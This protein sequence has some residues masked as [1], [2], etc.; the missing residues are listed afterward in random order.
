M[1]NCFV[2]CVIL[3]CGCACREYIGLV[4]M[5]AIEE[6]SRDFVPGKTFNFGKPTCTMD[7]E[8]LLASQ[9]SSAENT[10]VIHSK[11]VF[12]SAEVPTSSLPTLV[13]L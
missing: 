6:E 13:E 8:Q 1:S 2:C 5:D 12:S 7:F 11:V 9:G 3:L 10:F 4:D